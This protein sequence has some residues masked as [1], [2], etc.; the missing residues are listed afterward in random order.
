MSPATIDRALASS[1]P[2]LPKHGLTTT[3]P[4]SRLKRQVAIKT[5]AGLAACSKGLHPPR[6]KLELEAAKRTLTDRHGV[7]FLASRHPRAVLSELHRVA[8]KSARVVVGMCCRWTAK[9]SELSV[10]RISQ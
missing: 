7:N 10:T 1:R 8:A 9:L 4:G 3:R 6:L 2:G 5:V